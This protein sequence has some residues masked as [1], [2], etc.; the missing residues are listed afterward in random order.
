M[1]KKDDTFVPDLDSLEIPTGLPDLLKES[2]NRNQVVG[3]WGFHSHVDFSKMSSE[4]TNVWSFE[5]VFNFLRAFFGL[6]TPDHMEVI[7]YNATKQI[8]KDNLNQMTFLDELMLIMKNLNEP[9]WVIRLH[10]SIVGFLR[11]EWSPDKPVRLM[12][13]EP[14]SFIVW[15]G[16]DESGFQTCSLSYSLFS[17]QKLKGEDSLLWSINQPL[18]EKALQKW[19]KQ[20]GHVIDV[21]QGNSKDVS[22]YR[23]GFKTPVPEGAKPSFEEEL[24]NVSEEEIPDLDE[25]DL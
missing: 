21:V 15:G 22:L 13:Q 1:A 8:K 16:P 18:L 5:Q 6:V 14:C 3:S 23:H 7:T 24:P 25:L 2:T 17:S 4:E 20:S 19:E 10:L 9:I 12:I 11:T